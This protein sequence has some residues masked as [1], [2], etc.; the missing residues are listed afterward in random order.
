M[1]RKPRRT[2]RTAARGIS[3]AKDMLAV[4]NM[5]LEGKGGGST[6]GKERGGTG[7]ADGMRG[8]GGTGFLLTE[9]GG[10]RDITET[11]PT[12]V[13]FSIPFSESFGLPKC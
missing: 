3:E 6:D 13:T 1:R 12:S 11:S 8:E 7:G 4:R 2:R 5:K 10:K 9:F